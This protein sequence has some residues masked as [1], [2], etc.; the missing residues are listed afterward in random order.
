MNALTYAQ[1][2]LH[3]NVQTSQCF[4]LKSFKTFSIKQI[5]HCTGVTKITDVKQIYIKIR[6]QGIR[7]I[8]FFNFVKTNGLPSGGNIPKPLKQINSH[9]AIV[10]FYLSD[11]WKNAYIYC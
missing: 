8:L 6:S 1:N 10:T 2:I 5:A 7:L 3:K 11:D 4:R 9:I